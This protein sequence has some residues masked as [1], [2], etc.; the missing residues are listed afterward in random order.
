MVFFSTF[1]QG[2]LGSSTEV[3]WYV[4]TLA[5]EPWTFSKKV[6]AS[7]SE[8]KVRQKCRGN[9]RCIATFVKTLAIWKISKQRKRGF[10]YDGFPGKIKEVRVGDSFFEKGSAVRPSLRLYLLPKS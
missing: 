10:I 4:S 3:Q 1:L 9:R 8:L 5:Q 6:M 2:E 7:C